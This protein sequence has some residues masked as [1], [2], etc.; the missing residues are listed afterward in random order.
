MSTYKIKQGDNLSTIAKNNGISLSE[1]LKLN[2]QIKNQDLIYI[3]QAINLQSQQPKLVARPM[4]NSNTP[5]AV[6][7]KPVTKA[8]TPQQT[9]NEKIWE[10][11]SQKPSLT[12]KTFLQTNVK[13]T[14]DRF[15]DAEALKQ[16]MTQVGWAPSNE[17]ETKVA[18]QILQQEG[19]YSKKIDG[20][21]GNGSKAALRQYQI[22]NLPVDMSRY[23]MAMNALIGNIYPFDYNPTLSFDKMNIAG[24]NRILDLDLSNPEHVAEMN[25]IRKQ[26]DSDGNRIFSN[27]SEN[28]SNEE[29]QRR[30]RQRQDLI[31]LSAGKKQKYNNFR[32]IL[33]DD[34]SIAYEF[35]DPSINKQYLNRMY[36]AKKKF[37]TDANG[38]IV[39]YRKDD[40][41]K[42]Y[43]FIPLDRTNFLFNQYNGRGGKD[44]NGREYTELQ[45]VWDIA[46]LKLLKGSE[47]A[48]RIVIRGYDDE[49]TLGPHEQMTLPNSVYSGNSNNIDDDPEQE[50]LRYYS[51]PATIRYVYDIL[52][53][54]INK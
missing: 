19:L 4:V 26:V 10:V 16:K 42:Q 21:W 27:M 5:S 3:G 22:N 38:N 32:R 30:F 9:N 41:N 1:L 47:N 31:L 37:G 11:I 7:K 36:S 50:P 34:G 20:N 44:E 49:A 48:P 6:K 17:A 46:F 18:Q 14:R 29:M 54:F 2:P 23:G 28:I 35:T 24:F 15:I 51:S 25:A 12:P 33:L 52:K 53:D 45:D 13:Q 43:P 39:A 8:E 40:V